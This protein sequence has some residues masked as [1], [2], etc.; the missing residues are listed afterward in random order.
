MEYT[1]PMWWREAEQWERSC[2]GQEEEEGKVPRPGGR[3]RSR[4]KTA[5]PHHHRQ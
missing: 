3:S 2:G 4:S 5:A 1:E